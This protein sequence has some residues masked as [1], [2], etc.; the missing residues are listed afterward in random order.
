MY[1]EMESAKQT[2]I[3]ISSMRKIKIISRIIRI[4]KIGIHS[5][6]ITCLTSFSLYYFFSVTNFI[7]FDPLS[8]AFKYELSDLYA[9]ICSN[10]SPRLNKDI[11][12]VDIGYAKREEIAKIIRNIRLHEPAVIGLDVLFQPALD[13]LK[14][15]ELLQ[16]INETVNLVLPYNVDQSF[17]DKPDSVSTGYIDFLGNNGIIRNFVFSTRDSINNHPRFCFSSQVV[18][19]YNEH[20]FTRE[21]DLYRE[22]IKRINYFPL[23][24]EKIG[25]SQLEQAGDSLNFRD[26]IVLIG[27]LTEDDLHLTPMGEKM[28]GLKIHAYTLAT[29]L[30]N[31]PIENLNNAWINCILFL[32]CVLFAGLCYTLMDKMKGGSGFIIRITQTLLLI[33]YVLID[34]LIY[35]NCDKVIEKGMVFLLIICFTSFFADIYNG[36]L[37]YGNIL[38]KKIVKK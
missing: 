24:F 1:N 15:S 20:L 16:T 26:K 23:E 7:H 36:I 28:P 4:S 32:I 35:L 6:L 3:N 27:A 22:T 8:S 5:F 19:L 18:R 25:L 33:I 30:N 21:L 29:L 14:D 11:V 10:K 13:S 34:C 17:L 12:L 31:N 37:H 2:F 38:V 9:T